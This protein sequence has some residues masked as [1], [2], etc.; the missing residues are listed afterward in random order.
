MNK[1]TTVM[2]KISPFSLIL[3]LFT[4]GFGTVF[5]ER[6]CVYSGIY[7]RSRAED[8]QLHFN[9][10]V[11]LSSFKM[12]S[13]GSNCNFHKNLRGEYSF[14]RRFLFIPASYFLNYLNYCG[15]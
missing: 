1:R 2:G 12:V 5:A 3:S 4:D 10:Q 14:L 15:F 9:K 7:N 13:T 11:G 6:E 8:K